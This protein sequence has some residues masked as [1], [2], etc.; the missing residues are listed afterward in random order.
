MA[1]HGAGEISI[2][3]WAFSESEVFDFSV[4]RRKK[5]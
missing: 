3:T 4:E 2:S 5:L 1:W